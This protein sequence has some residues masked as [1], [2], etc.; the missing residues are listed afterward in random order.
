M[1][2]PFVALACVASA[3]LS[4]AADGFAVKLV[5]QWLWLP[6]LGLQRLVLFSAFGR[7][8]SSFRFSVRGAV[9]FGFYALRLLCFWLPVGGALP[10]ALALKKNVFS[11]N[12]RKL[13]KQVEKFTASG[14][15]LAAHCLLLSVCGSLSSLVTRSGYC[16][17][18]F[19]VGGALSLVFGRRCMVFAFRFVVQSLLVLLGAVVVVLALGRRC[20][21]C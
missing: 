7:W 19:S 4:L 15:R 8:C 11:S 9:A 2:R 20:I 12:G 13:T 16:D 21:I 14:F 3:R 1:G 17:F 10:L 6:A 5:V 18:R